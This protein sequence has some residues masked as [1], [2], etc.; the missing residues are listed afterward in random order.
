MLCS[1]C[2]K[3][4][5]V[6]FMSRM[7]GNET[8]NEGL[9]L[10]CAKELGIPQVASM[11]DS[12]GITDDDIEEMSNQLMELGEDD[13]EMGGADT[14][15]PFLQNIFGGMG[16]LSKKSDIPEKDSAA[17]EKKREKGKEQKKNKF[18]DS[19][20]INLTEKARS[21]NL[22]RIIG[23]DTEIAR[24]VQI[25]NRRVKNNPCLI[26]EPGVGKTAIVEGIALKIAAGQ[27]P[28]RLQD[29]E[30][31]LLDMTSLVSGTQFRGQFESRIK[32]LIDDIKNAK[33]VILFID[34]VHTLVGAGSAE[35]SMDAAN[36]LKP[37]LSRGDIQVIGATTF[38]EYR[39]HIEKDS[40]LER[41][42]QPITV[43]E[44]TIA[45]TTDV[46]L[47]VKSYYEAFHKIK[48][49]DSIV[50]LSVKLS[51]R[52]IIDRFLPDKAIDLLDEACSHAALRSKELA[53]YEKLNQKLKEMMNAEEQ[54]ESDP[55]NIDYEKLAEIKSNLIQTKEELK[56]LEPIVADIQLTKEDL[57][58]VIEMWTG[59]PAAK[60]EQSE[61]GKISELENHLKS[62][63]IG[64][65]EAV[66][67]VV[68]AVKRSRVQLNKRKRPASFIFVGPTGVGKTEL[69]KCLADELFET[70]DPLIRFDMSEFMEKHAV[71]RL[72][73]AP[74][75]YVGYEEA[76]QLT[77]RVRR[78]PYSVVLF[79]EIEKA[80]PDVMNILLQILDEGKVTDAQGRTVSFQ[81]TVIVM[82]S[83]AGSSDKSNIVGF[84]KQAGEMA[85]E[86]AMRALQEILRP[87][88]LGR[89][90]EIVVFS[91]LSQESMQ[92]IAGL[93]LDEMK[94]PLK[95]QNIEMN[96]D[97]KALAYLAQH[98]DGG[99]F[100]A[101][102]LRKV[103]RKKVEDRVAN[104]IVDHYDNPITMLGITADENDIQIIAK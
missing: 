28:F 15:P 37:S 67:L 77:E 54:L 4:M 101:R 38:D 12:M 56:K 78:K 48:I 104:M 91:P 8:I 97:E 3:R 34:E 99:K 63:V 25:L 85:K 58:K 6:V 83:N 71:S 17:K 61:Y 66:S 94:E 44:P 69:V 11:M 76:G 57:A 35:G 95:E 89:V 96:Y 68:A 42:F 90:D 26:G 79:D 92:K 62:K 53:S 84:N 59:I 36:I 23:R 98:A 87:E 75:G 81:N 50:R 102:E 45:E 30:I 18:L 10:K 64:Q 33:N 29:K 1:R 72:V 13:F 39:K 32:G 100:G 51:E 93:M 80:H 60:I 14:M 65:D 40:A 47:G 31:Y 21:G 9:C 74:P 5:A 7:E 27:V 103:I 24:A 20:C 19:Y 70:A 22:D 52:Y 88:L 41:R 2:K 16:D 49:S 55:E 46:L 73:G 82:T 43:N 86:K